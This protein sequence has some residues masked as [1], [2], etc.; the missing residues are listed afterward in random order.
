M[1]RITLPK[2]AMIALLVMVA[3]LV[4]T[5]AVYAGTIMA[6]VNP[7]GQIR[8]IGPGDSCRPQE[9][10]LEWNITGPEGLPGA[11]GSPGPPGPPGPP[12]LSNI[13]VVGEWGPNNSEDSKTHVVWCP[14]DMTAISGG[15]NISGGGLNIVVRTFH[16]QFDGGTVPTGWQVSAHE[17]VPT[18][19]EWQIRAVA[20]CADVEE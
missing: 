11:D 9:T 6:C 12:G 1:N 10:S 20:V 3:M 4:A 8:I 2:W 7:A 14:L 19:E 17:I 16:P 13:E 5:T 18:D 15:F